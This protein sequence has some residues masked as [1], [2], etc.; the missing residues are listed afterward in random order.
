M[1]TVQVLLLPSFLDFASNFFLLQDVFIIPDGAPGAI[2]ELERRKFTAE[3]GVR[4]R[5]TYPPM[6]HL[7]YSRT[8]SRC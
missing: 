5:N 3:E 2:A 1:T 7:I 6:S 4:C 8:T